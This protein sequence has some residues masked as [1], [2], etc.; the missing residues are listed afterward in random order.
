MSTPE[1][2]TMI[3][4]YRRNV[5]VLSLERAKAAPLEISLNMAKVREDP[6]FFDLLAPHFQNTEILRI[7]GL[8][9]IGDL[10]FFIQHPMDNLR[11]L[12]LSDLPG[13][14]NW[15]RSIDPFESS[16]HAL[17]YLKLFQVPL[18]P[19]FLNLRTL[20]ELDLYDS[21]CNLHLDTILDFMEGNDSLKSARLE[22]WF[23]EPSLRNSR[24]QAPIQNQL[25][26]LRIG[27][28][29]MMDGQ[30][31]ISGIALSKGAKLEFHCIKK[32]VVH[33]VLT[34]I[35]TTHLSNLLSPTFMRY[36]V[37]PRTI[38]LHGPNGAGS[39]S[40]LSNSG[41]P[42]EEF[43][44]LP[45]T[46]IRQFHFGSWGWG[47]FRPPPDPMAF[48]HL[49]FFPALEAF[50]LC[51]V[52]P[53]HHL[54][55]L[56]SNP[57]VLPSLNTLAFSNCDLTQEFMEGLT[58][59]ASD[60]KRTTSAWLHRVVI[61]HSDGILPNITSIRGLRSHVPVVDVRIAEGLPTDL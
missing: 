32:A 38:E 48:H 24:R 16:A 53:S 20:T 49:T 29:D 51:G 36:C 15:D 5:A 22:I 19:S 14:G 21:R 27:S 4:N 39:F 1:N 55:T 2:W 60:R 41:I 30:A 3:S 35:S 7:S 44:R 57:S 18:Y 9:T 34:S 37:R 54:S 31:L 52:N 50:I 13:V 25:Q 45:L 17:R 58:R 6:Q 33:S 11:S 56:L 47:V 40:T 59:F 61:I 43:P 12:A 28:K 26:Y 46:N 42:F 23:T 10:S 8:S